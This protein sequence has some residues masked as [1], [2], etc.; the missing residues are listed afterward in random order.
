MKRQGRKHKVVDTNVLVAANKK[1]GES[2]ICATSCARALLAIKKIGVIVI[3]DADFI[4]A[5]YRRNC[6]MSGQ[7]GVGDSFIRWIHDNLG[8]RDLTETVAITPKGEGGADG[9]DEFPEHN[10]LRTFDPSDRKFVAV[11][12]A[13]EAKPPILQALDS[14]WW[15]WKDALLACGITVEFLCPDEIRETYERKFGAP[16]IGEVGER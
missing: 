7:P 15:G 10:G 14:K 1:H 9:Y 12:N 3:D 5:E 4:L 2:Y 6:S 16:E 13:H 11:A 8:K